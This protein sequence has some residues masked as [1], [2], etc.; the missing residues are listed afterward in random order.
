MKGRLKNIFMKTNKKG[1]IIVLIFTVL[2]LIFFVY[3][4]IQ[5][6]EIYNKFSYGITVSIMIAMFIAIFI[7]FLYFMYLILENKD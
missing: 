5:L 2:Y 7:Y 3:G 1:K 6:K 4:I